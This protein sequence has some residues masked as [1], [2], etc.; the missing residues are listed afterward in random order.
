M[1]PKRSLQILVSA[2]ISLTV[3][4][5]VR[6]TAAQA[7]E[8]AQ[9][10]YG[11]ANGL[12][13]KPGDK[14]LTIGSGAGIW[15]YT[16]NLDRIGRLS[17]GE[18]PE[19]VAGVAWSADGS[20]LCA[21]LEDETLEIWDGVELGSTVRGRLVTK[22]PKAGK[23][24]SWNPNGNQLASASS[25][26]AVRVWDAK[27]GE[28]VFALPGAG[29]VVA[30]SPDGT[31][32]ATGNSDGVT[33]WEAHSRARRLVLKKGT[34]GAT[35]FIM[36][37]PNGKFLSS[38]GPGDINSIFD[39]TYIWDFQAGKQ[40]A[41][42][43]DIRQVAWSPDGRLLAGILTL[44]GSLH[45]YIQIFDT[46]TWNVL[47]DINS[48]TMIN[49]IAWTQSG[50]K[51]TTAG[52]DGQVQLWNPRTGQALE[53]RQL[54]GSPINSVT[55]S[56]SGD[57][58]AASS[59]GNSHP[60]IVWKTLPLGPHLRIDPVS[61][62]RE[63]VVTSLVFS[64][65]DAQLVT[66]SELTLGTF[67]YAVRS[68]DVASGKRLITLVAHQSQSSPP[69]VVGLSPDFSLIAYADNEV[70]TVTIAT[71]LAQKT[72][73][74]FPATSVS[75]VAWSADGRLIAVSSHESAKS[76]FTIQV[77]D[78]VSRT[79][80]LRANRPDPIYSLMW[81][82]DGKMLATAEYNS[83]AKRYS[84]RVLSAKTGQVLTSAS[85]SAWRSMA[86]SLNSQ[87][88][89]VAT[90]EGVGILSITSGQIVT[91]VKG[92]GAASV[93]WHPGQR[94]LALGLKNGTVKILDFGASA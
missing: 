69:P 40:V 61:T 1:N 82:P 60:I 12:A 70:G 83:G 39:S 58:L 38:I 6:S 30:W 4:L 41:N 73:F 43:N 31:L 48:P 19:D 52:G 8:I 88:L 3:A 57:M 55:W 77:W 23:S 36:W 2:L 26:N 7:V 65:D 63:D 13:W 21:I 46:D 22:I 62:I 35:N 89:A 90:G 29:H 86:W 75:Q 47:S 51:L 10:G 25:N 34:G 79:L 49:S 28:L 71:A 20:K 33:V 64:P 16:D 24:V 56:R 94:I 72:L 45:G 44:Q 15:L 53:S 59:Y 68:W 17:P 42:L 32:L 74:E 85:I 93:A 9:L 76:Y 91:I 87:T 66:F 92:R 5:P 78:V 14:V 18:I 80:L 67:Y 84:L 37:S 27:T 50:D 81:S 54:H 11:T